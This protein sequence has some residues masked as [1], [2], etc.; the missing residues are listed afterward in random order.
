[1]Y[2]LKKKRESVI[3]LIFGF[4]L[5]SLLFLSVQKKVKI[6]IYFHEKRNKIYF[7]LSF[8]VAL[9]LLPL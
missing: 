4:H 8:C 2:F 9:F 6:F 1:M 5:E 7:I 3:D